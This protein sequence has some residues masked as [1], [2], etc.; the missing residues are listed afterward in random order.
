MPV[1]LWPTEFGTIE[2]QT[3][4]SILRE[5]ARGLG[6][7]TANIVVG[8]V[9]YV[10]P[11]IPGQF[12][13]VLSI[14]SSALSYRMPLVYVEH[15]IDLY[16]ASIQV[17]G[18]PADSPPLQANNPDELAAHL[19]EIFARGKTKKMIASMKAQSIE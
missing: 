19:K 17:E 6:E 14:Y 12:R 2:Q 3:P 13:H 11:T 8:Q 1:N 10:V 4:V 9:D 16:P 15:G 5:Q 7:R 18:D